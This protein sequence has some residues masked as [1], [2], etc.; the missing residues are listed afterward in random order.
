V[1]PSPQWV[2][3]VGGAGL[4]EVRRAVARRGLRAVALADAA[5]LEE[6]PD[7]PV[8]VAREEV[9]F[10]RPSSLVGRLQDLHRAGRLAAI[11]PFTEFG[12]LPAAIAAE[13]LGL[14]TTPATAVRRTR[15]KVVMRR[16]LAEAGFHRPRFLL[17]R[18]AAQVETFRRAVGGTVVVKPSASTGSL[19][20]CRVDSAAGAAAAFAT[21]REARGGGSVLCEE[22]LEGP[23]VSVEAVVAGG[24]FLPVAVTAKRLGDGF[25]EVGHVQPAMLP[26]E[27]E[28]ELLALVRD[29]LAALGVEEAV[30]HTEVR[31]TPAGPAL[32]ETHTRMGG[33]RI[34]RLTELTTGVDLADVTVA[35]ALGEEPEVRPRST[36]RAAAIHYLVGGPGPA[37]L[38]AIEAPPEDLLAAVEDYRLEAGAGQTVG[39]CRSSS[40]RL[41]WA[42]AVGV[43]A[44]A[45][46]AAARRW[47]DSV[48][49]TWDAATSAT[50]PGAAAV[51]AGEGSPC[52]AAS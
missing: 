6:M 33:D 32:V 50:G 11:V 37:R 42:L 31:L 1:A 8:I 12:L 27:R 51:L 44:G 16:A 3:L 18:E 19:A 9:D 14:P 23:E 43:D 7:D 24:R 52:R 13:R 36:G 49:L 29:V 20:V 46:E 4:P 41:G 5:T 25:M 38:A 2:A 48:R 45:A 35:L 34:H 10:A 28:V 47:V 26:G 39:P 30:T 22:Y 17:C 40:D 15:D 21:A